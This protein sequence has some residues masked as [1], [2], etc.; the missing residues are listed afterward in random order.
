MSKVE[1]IDE[2]DL[3]NNLRN[4]FFKK[5]IHTNVGNTLIVTNPFEKIVGCYGNTVIEDYIKVGLFLK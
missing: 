2:V 3:L 4:R 1:D 5:N